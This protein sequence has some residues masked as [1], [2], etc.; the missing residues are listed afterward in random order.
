MDNFSIVIPIYNEELYLKYQL[1]KLMEKISKLTLGL[2]YEILLVENG[3]TDQTLK[4]AQK[5]SRCFRQ[6]KVFS[7]ANPSYGQA[8]KTGVLHAGYPVVFQFDLDFW[9]VTFLRKSLQILEDSDIVIG[10][11]NLKKSSD[12]RSLGR[13]LM[14]VFVEKILRIR[15][16]SAITD[17]HGLKAYKRN[18]IISILDS[19]QSPNHFFDSELLIRCEQLGYRIKELPVTLSEIRKSRFPFLVRGKDAAFELAMLI[20]PIWIKHLDLS[21]GFR[22]LK[23]M[24]KTVSQLYALFI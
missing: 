22:I 5:L 6:I 2:K 13:K 19:I 9:D 20:T 17:T 15:F 4:L 24:N 23:L 11:K 10:S 12:Q 1:K 16:G 18:S 8:F 21:G 7:I 3:S 14:S